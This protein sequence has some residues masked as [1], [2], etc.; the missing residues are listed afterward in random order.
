MH[1]RSLLQEF[2][3]CLYSLALWPHLPSPSFHKFC[4]DFYL[5]R[6]RRS[7]GTL[8]SSTIRAL[9]RLQLQPSPKL[10]MLLYWQVGNCQEQQQS[11]LVVGKVP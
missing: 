6:M 3:D 11:P 2:A 7:S 4:E 5:R 1:D 9:Q 10:L 8:L